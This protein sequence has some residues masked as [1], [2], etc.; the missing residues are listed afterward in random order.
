MELLLMPSMVFTLHIVCALSCFVALRF[1]STIVFIIVAETENR[2]DD[3]LLLEYTEEE[4]PLLQYIETIIIQIYCIY[5]LNSV[6]HLHLHKPAGYDFGTVIKLQSWISNLL[7]KSNLLAKLASMSK[8][9]EDIVRRAQY[10]VTEN[11]TGLNYI[12]SHV[13]FISTDIKGICSNTVI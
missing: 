2:M 12:L 11:Y 8:C 10:L 9:S 13:L 1:N 5:L 4:H 3:L 6:V 7:T